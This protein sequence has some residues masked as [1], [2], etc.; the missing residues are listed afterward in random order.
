M[1][2]VVLDDKKDFF[3]TLSTKAKDS[4]EIILATD[5][6]REGEAIAA[7]IASEV[8][9]AKLSRVNLLRLPIPG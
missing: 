9:G 6:D 2:L 7:H 4:S 3:K 8:P 5:P 1:E